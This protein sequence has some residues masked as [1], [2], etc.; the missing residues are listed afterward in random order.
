MSGRS[1][2]HVGPLFHALEGYD[3]YDVQ[4]LWI[5]FLYYGCDRAGQI[6]EIG[7]LRRDGWGEGHGNYEVPRW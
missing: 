2:S 1:H 3:G 6:E 4:R 7:S 5:M